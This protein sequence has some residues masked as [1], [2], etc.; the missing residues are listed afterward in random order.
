MTFPELGLCFPE[1]QPFLNF[2]DTLPLRSKIVRKFWM[3]FMHEF[4]ENFKCKRMQM[5][6]KRSKLCI[7]PASD[8]FNGSIIEHIRTGTKVVHTKYKLQS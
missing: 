1:S 4:Q 2:A 3:N 7:T 5:D 6:S 8:D